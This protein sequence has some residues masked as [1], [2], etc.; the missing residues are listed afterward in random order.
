MTKGTQNIDQTKAVT[1]ETILK[2]TKEVVIKFIEVGKVSPANFDS[3]F[4]KIFSTIEQT[5]NSKTQ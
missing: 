2:V 4:K 1:Q 5:I 3:C